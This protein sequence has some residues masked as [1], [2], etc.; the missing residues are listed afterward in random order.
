M[1]AEVRVRG[2]EIAK[3]LWEMNIGAHLFGLLHAV[4]HDF[5]PMFGIATSG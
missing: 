5:D 2:G 4:A 1:L 3:S